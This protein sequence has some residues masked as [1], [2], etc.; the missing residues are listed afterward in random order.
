MSDFANDLKNSASGL[1]KCCVFQ[2]ND[3]SHTLSSSFFLFLKKQGGII[4]DNFKG[5]VTKSE[6][7]NKAKV[8]KRTWKQEK[9]Y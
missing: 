5:K 7:L 9:N 6:K 4:K 8:I 2:T 1:F 3:W